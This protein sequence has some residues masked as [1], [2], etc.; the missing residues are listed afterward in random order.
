MGDSPRTPIPLIKLRPKQRHAR[1]TGARMFLQALKFV[2][3]L[4]D[5]AETTFKQTTLDVC[6]DMFF[7]S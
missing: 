4:S 2:S 6:S 3:A 5:R 1:I 7:L